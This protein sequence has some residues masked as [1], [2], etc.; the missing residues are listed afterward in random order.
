M[1]DGYMLS[2]GHTVDDLNIKT[3][4]EAVGPFEKLFVE[5]R[6][7]LEENSSLCTDDEADRLQICQI[8]SRHLSRNLKKYCDKQH[9]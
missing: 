9:Q 7:L 6:G 1:D 4:K 5:I 8:V 3:M 2:E